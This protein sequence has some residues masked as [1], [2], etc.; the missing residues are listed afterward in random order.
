MN[1]QTKTMKMKLTKREKEVLKLISEGLT[2]KEI[3]DK[4]GVSK[5]TI[6]AHTSNML[7]KT[8]ANNAVRLVMWAV[9]NGELKI[10][11]ARVRLK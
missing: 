7:R 11:K 8:G 1:L 5:R 6:D 4:L 3:S 10:K 2:A 9:E